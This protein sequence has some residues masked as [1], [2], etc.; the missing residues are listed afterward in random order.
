MRSIKNE[1]GNHLFDLYLYLIGCS[2]DETLYFVYSVTANP[3][4]ASGEAAL[5]LS[6][7]FDTR[8][9]P[10]AFL[11][12]ASSLFSLI[13]LSLR[14]FSYRRNLEITS[15]IAVHTGCPLSRLPVG[16]HSNCSPTHS[17][18]PEVQSGSLGHARVRCHSR[19]ANN[20]VQSRRERRWF[21]C[22]VFCRTV[23]MPGETCQLLRWEWE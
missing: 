10:A 6:H 4:Q 2:N 8:L 15:Y 13:I 3:P 23:L 9:L 7:L 16:S 1:N 22:V 5:N 20:G 17:Q 11:P 18:H 14:W 12:D 21:K 19:G